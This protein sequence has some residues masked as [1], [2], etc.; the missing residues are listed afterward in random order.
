MKEEN[1]S[2]ADQ[3]TFYLTTP[4]YYPSDKLHIGHAYTTVAGDAM[5]RYKRL[6]GYE[7]RYL[8]GTDEHGQKIERKAQEKGQSPQAFVD[9]IVVGIKELWNKL[10]ISNDDFI[11]TTEERHKTVVQ[12]IFDRLLK[13][14]DIYKGEYEGWYSIPD[15]T[16]YTETQLVD[17]E[18][19]DKGEII[20]AKSP[21]SGH[22][23]ELVKEESYFFRMSKYADRLLRYY[24]ENPGFI[25]PE[26]RKNEM[27]NNFIKPGLEDLA[28]SRTTFEWGVKVKGDPK[29]VVYVWIDALSNYITALGYGSS[30]ESLYNKFWPADVHLVGKEIVRFHTIYWPIMLMALDLPLPKKVFAHGWLLMKD[31]KMSKSKGNVVDPV[32]LIDR[33][34]LDALRYYLLREVPFGS[35]GTFTPESFVERVNS[36]LANDLG[37][38]LNRT[39]AM[40]DKYFEG[41]APEFTSGVTEFDASLEEAGLAAVEKVEQAMENLQFS[42]ALTAISQFVS[43]SN[44]YIDETQPWALARD[45][46]KRNELASVMSHLIE[47]L[48]IASILLQ[49][50]LTRAPRKIWEQLGIQEGELTAWDT[51]KQ[52]GVIPA[53]NALQ[54][55]DPIF[56]RLD[57]EQEI[58]YIAEA[59]TGGKKA[60]AQPEAAQADAGG[61]S[62]AAQPVTAPEGKEEISIDDFAKVEL[63]VAQ[64]IACEPVKKADKLLKLQ[65]DLG[66]EQRQVV[67][68]IAKFYSPEDM[69]GRKVIC[70]TNLKP[71]KLR[72]ELSQGMILAASHGDQLTLATVPDNMPNGAQVK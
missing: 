56:P 47:S 36:D 30:D 13:Q 53:G 33:Y 7:V 49:P 41:K 20:S 31:G 70:V 46:A 6:R 55:G 51:A 43:R 68:G 27:I 54:K 25:Q 45:E 17:V 58:A 15:E 62:E 64:V 11:R 44:K 67:S 24:E 37:N 26:S 9:D 34:G 63:R 60:E 21:D 5:V 10:D 23:V 4:I 50:F 61:S 72:G 18:K 39:V 22:P 3:K 2:M 42:V 32:T 14:G 19:N 8:T 57:S 52:W 48:R 28:V 65:L 66:Y 35:D 1:S 69:V 38:L 12:D 59:M 40:V 16:Y 29:H 71:V